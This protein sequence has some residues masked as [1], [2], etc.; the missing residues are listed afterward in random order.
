MPKAVPFKFARC[1]KCA[2]L[3]D[4]ETDVVSW[5]QTDSRLCKQPPI[6]KCLD[7]QTAIE[8]QEMDAQKTTP[9]P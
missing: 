9:Y 4:V 2:A 7:M 8:A 6:E 5:N 1:A 3:A